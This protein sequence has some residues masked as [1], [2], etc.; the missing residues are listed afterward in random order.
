MASST[1]PLLHDNRVLASSFVLALLVYLVMI[2]GPLAWLEAIA[3]VAPFDMRPGG[4]SLVEARALLAA[5][6]VDGRRLYLTTQIPL[7]MV[8]PGLLG[9]SL[10][11]ALTRLATGFR[12]RLG[13]VLRLLRWT[14]VLAAVADYAENLMIT[15]MLISASP[16]DGGTVALASAASTAKAGLTTLAA[17][18]VLVGAAV[19]AVRRLAAKPT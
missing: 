18:A 19:H 15:V 16:P 17:T 8:Y 5:L 12:G 6:G 2:F 11:I 10:F 7:D 1:R 9:L 3:G 13:A 4:Y 14:A